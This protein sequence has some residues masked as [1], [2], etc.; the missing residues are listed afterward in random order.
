M[1]SASANFMK[2]NDQRGGSLVE[3]AV[4][5]PLLF[6]ILF[7]IIEFGILFYDRAMI[8]NASR[9]AARAGIVYNF[10][11]DS[12][13]RISDAEIRQVVRDY[14]EDHLI[15]FGEG[16]TLTIPIERTGNEAGDILTVTVNYPFR[17]LVFSNVLALIGGNV[18]GLVN[19]SAETIM[20]LE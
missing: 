5:A 8:T 15:S 19:L 7:G 17:F 13:P 4:I 11:P 16:S 10:I 1:K 14:C 2:W 20:R 12:P 9:E 6:V 18:G 3:F